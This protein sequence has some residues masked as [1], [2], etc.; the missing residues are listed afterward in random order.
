MTQ[1]KFDCVAD[2]LP[3]RA[4][5]LLLNDVIAVTDNT[6]TARVMIQ[7]NSA[8]YLPNA[9]VPACIGLEYMGQTAAL[10]AG[11][12]QRQGQSEP[13][14]GYLLGSRMYRQNASHFTLG[15]QLII[16]AEAGTVVG[17]ELANFNCTILEE[18][19]QALLCQGTLSVMRKPISE[20]T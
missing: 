3:H 6:A 5:M 11:L 19:S 8:F 20:S 18:H 1:S 14:L 13:Q 17:T 7:H 12:A 4:T 10:I 2:L 16:H 9:G 15:Q